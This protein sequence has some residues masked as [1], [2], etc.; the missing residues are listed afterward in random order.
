MFSFFACWCAILSTN[1]E[2]NWLGTKHKLFFCFAIVQQDTRE[3][4]LALTRSSGYSFYLILRWM[5]KFI[6]KQH[7]EVPF[8]T[9]KNPECRFIVH[10]YS[11]FLQWTQSTRWQACSRFGNYTCAVHKILVTANK[12]QTAYPF[13]H[14]SCN[15]DHVTYRKKSLSQEV[16]QLNYMF[17]PLKF[18]QTWFWMCKSWSVFHYF[19]S[20]NAYFSVTID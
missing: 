17:Y 4:T 10:V 18:D 1:Q 7:T 15:S 14:F 16:W 13:V 6:Y 11:N 2:F 3:Q 19:M 9:P 20:W 5:E 12:S 8:K